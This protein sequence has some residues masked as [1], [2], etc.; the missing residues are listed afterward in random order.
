MA[1][2]RRLSV[3]IPVV[4][5]AACFVGIYLT[6]GAM[7]R[8]PFLKGK[9]RGAA[10]ELVDQ[11]PWQTAQA[12]AAMAVSA[13]EREFARQALRLADH[14]VNQAFAQALREASVQTKQLPP[15]AEQ[16]QQKVTVLQGILKDDQ[17]KVDQLTAATK[18]APS[19]NTDDAD[20]AKAQVQLD[21]DEVDDATEDLARASGDKRGEIQQ[22]L[23]TREAEVKKYEDQ[24][25]DLTQTAVASVK[26]YGTLA[27]R[28]GAWFDQRTRMDALAQAQAEADADAKALASQ[29][30]DIEKRLNAG[31]TS[32]GTASAGEDAKTRMVKLGQMHSLAQ[33]H[34]ILD[35]RVQTQQQLSQVYGRWLSQVQ[36]QHSIVLHMILQSI[37]WI[38]FLALFSVIATL[39]A[40]KMLDRFTIID[41]RRLHTLRTV[42]TLGIQV[43]VLLMMVLVIFGPPSQIPTILGLAT[44]GI[45]VVFQDFIIA[46]FGW[47]VLMGKNGIH[48]GDW[49]EINGVGGE[50]VEVGLFRT[51]LLETGNWTDKGHPTGR[52]VTV[53]NSFAITGQYFNLSTAGQWLW[54]EIT[55]NV[56]SGPNGAKIIE[57]IQEALAK[58]TAADTKQ[59]EAEWQRVTQQRGLSQ[60]SPQPSVDL[61]PSGSGVDVVVRYVTRA[62]NRFEMRNKIYQAVI[63]F[64]HDETEKD[65]QQKLEAPVKR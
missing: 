1:F 51:S 9:A 29:H 32:G 52:R 55:V 65:E 15:D 22:E 30:A 47:F 12:V 20:V 24:N 43:V 34:G 59:A 44:A 45:T 17:S 2:L 28:I 35:D 40:N 36:L 37:A 48:V 53:M 27:G 10:S 19:G 62:D 60:F 4:I 50:V 16:L 42:I 18:S 26:K 13:E 58:E 63:A 64:L 38:A 7:Q 6:Q 23:T 57:A 11:R 31:D 14:E 49:V 21:K 46:F 56:P 33:I 25:T 3:L 41:R 8:L 54:D 61:R 5:L 39:V